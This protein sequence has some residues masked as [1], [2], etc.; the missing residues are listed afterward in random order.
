M[1][2]DAR[3][4]ECDSGGS[5]LMCSYSGLSMRKHLAADSPFGK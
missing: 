3:F 5:G 4:N 2:K 1:A